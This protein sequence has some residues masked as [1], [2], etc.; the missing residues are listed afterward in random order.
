L[1]RG[2]RERFAAPDPSLAEVAAIVAAVAELEDLPSAPAGEVEDARAE[3]AIGRGWKARA[4]LEGL[5]R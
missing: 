4:R 3:G 2:S 5:R 1:Q